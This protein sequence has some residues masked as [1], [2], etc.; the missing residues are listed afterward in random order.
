MPTVLAFDIGI[1]NLA[2]CILR[3]DTSGSIPAIIALEN[4]NLMASLPI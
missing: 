2:F 4:I 3:Q 1:K